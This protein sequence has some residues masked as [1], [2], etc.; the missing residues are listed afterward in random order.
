MRSSEPE[1]TTQHQIWQLT[2]ASDSLKETKTTTQ[3][4]FKR[5]LGLS[6]KSN[7]FNVLKF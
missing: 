6:M 5:K 4:T 1:N 3:H 2:R 7:Y